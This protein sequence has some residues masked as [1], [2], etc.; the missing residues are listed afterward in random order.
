LFRRSRWWAPIFHG[1]RGAM[2]RR[3]TSNPFDIELHVEDGIP[4][5]VQ[6]R[7]KTKI[8]EL[9]RYASAPILHARLRLSR[10]RHPAVPRPVMAQANLDVNGRLLRAQVAAPTATEAVDLLDYRMRRQ[11]RRMARHWE[12]KRGAMPKQEPNE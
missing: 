8:E 5:S 7:A 3:T 11:L 2:K 12:A 10:P 4:D 1:W 6:D 9:T